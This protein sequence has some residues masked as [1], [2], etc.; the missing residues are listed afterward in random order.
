[1]LAMFL[2]IAENVLFIFIE[3]T[4]LIVYGFSNT[5]EEKTFLNLGYSLIV[6]Y[7]ITIILA[8]VRFV[9]YLYSKFRNITLNFYGLDGG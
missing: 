4:L 2:K 9:Y 5:M 3:I 1:M 6:L 8:L 7:V